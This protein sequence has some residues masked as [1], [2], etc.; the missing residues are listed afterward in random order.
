MKK[1]FFKKIV[2][3]FLSLAVVLGMA[4]TQAL[5]APTWGSETSGSLTIHKTDQTGANIAGAGYTLYKVADVVQTG[6]TMEYQ[7]TVNGVTVTGSTRPADF[8]GETL[9]AY[10]PEQVTDGTNDLVWEDL[11]LGVYLVKETSTPEGVIQS[12]DFIVSIPMTNATGDGWIY[13]VV[14]EPKNSVFS[15]GISKTVT[16]GGEAAGTGEWTVNVGEVMEYTIEVTMPSDFYGATG[17][18][19]YTLFDIID[20]MDTGLKLIPSSVEATVGGNAVTVTVNEGKVGE[21]STAVPPVY[22]MP[23]GNGF[24]VSMVNAAKDG[25][26]D[27]AIVAGS[28]VVITY[29]AVVTAEG[30]GADLTN[31]ASIIYDYVGSSGPGKQDP[32]PEDDPLPVVHSYSHAAL[33]VDD[34]DVALNDAEFILQLE[35][36]K[37]LKLNAT[38]D[39]WEE[40]DSA[41]DAYVFVAGSSSPMNTFTDDGYFSIIGVKGG[42]HQLIETKAPEGF[43]LLKTPVTITFN[44]NTTDT[45]QEDAYTTTIVNAKGFSLPGTGGAG[46][47]IYIAGGVVLLAMGLILYKKR[48]SMA[49]E[50]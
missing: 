23:N 15:G 17:N 32:G 46:I 7:S 27:T 45:Q 4:S 41:D 30:V 49:V 42:D 20:K 39:G 34:K 29:Q 3:L 40:V 33:K 10:G 24:T 26:T 12:N 1:Q 44:Q 25:S 47:V 11:P 2:G 13:D 19:T 43:T 8:E 35:S 28:T 6:S 50:N 9:T 48:R 22:S 31:T 38:N 16:S 14:A 18:K 37:Y 36:G 21:L 5:A